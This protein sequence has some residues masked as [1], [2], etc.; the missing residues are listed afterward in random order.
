MPDDSTVAV[1][2]SHSSPR[3]LVIA[4]WVAVAAAVALR[5]WNAFASPL[6]WGY[7][8]AGHVAYVFY[9]DRYGAI[10]WAH[11]GWGYFHP[12]LHYLFGWG[13][14]QFG[15]AEVLLRGL[16]LLGSAAGLAIAAL[17]ASVARALNP[18][19]PA[20]A[21]FA[22]IAL[23]F[24]PVHVYASPMSGNELTCALFGAAA[25]ASL[26]ANERRARPQLAHD[27][28]TGCF[29]G[30]ALLS[31]F[32]GATVLAGCVV[33]ILL[34]PVVFGGGSQAG[35]LALR[36][37]L[38]LAAVV[39]ILAGP[40]YARNFERYGTPFRMN[41]DYALT[42]DVEE[43]QAPGSRSWRDFVA[44]SPKLL[45]DPRPGADHLL[46][47]V[48]GSAYVNA[49]VDA[50]ALWNRLPDPEAER[51]RRA[52]IAMIWLGLLPTALAILGA[53]AAIGDLRRGRRVAGYLPLLVF[54][55]LALF[56]F[57]VFSVRVPRISALKASYLMGLSLPYG[58]FV[59]R[60]VEALA[61]GRGR[62]FAVAGCVAVV[63][64]AVAAGVIYRVGGV[65]P[66]RNH[67]RALGAVHLLAGDTAAARA[68]YR[69]RL[70][71]TPESTVW[72]QGLAAVELADGAVERAS[73]LYGEVLMQR[74]SDPQT[75]ERLGV[76]EALSGNI[77]AAR[78][79]FDRALAL[80][81]GESVLANRGAVFAELGDL[82]AAASDLERALLAD[83][84]FAVAAHN[85]AVVHERAG[86]DEVATLAR[87][88][89]LRATAGSP[90]GY[91][92][93]VGVGLLEPGARPLLWLAPD[94]LRLAEAPFDIE[95]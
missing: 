7:D 65:H 70:E 64:P 3:T 33:V 13:L 43:T 28:L 24:L 10:P 8:A 76:A 44:V 22:F 54:A 58:V 31:K 21:L 63:V 90:S 18:A 71:S 27:A 75:T 82:A 79:H 1:E 36:R 9:L 62:A 85:L 4:W 38:V 14:A 46:H 30:L 41:R 53:I 73:Q 92:Y 61:R 83:P 80:G 42:A 29:V 74:R 86:R 35:L 15:S 67:G 45:S 16:A 40:F 88:H 87:R 51:L 78:R 20:L 68:F 34:R 11:Q 25:L 72:K 81:G 84:D 6:M 17:A 94:G 48:W 60:G 39:V 77:E 66:T 49:W 37:A 89:W 26:I 12:P 32:S 59:A 91:P 47:S 57:A 52:R 50:R 19:R 2:P 93:G 23:A 5:L 95:P 55:A 56:A 69:D